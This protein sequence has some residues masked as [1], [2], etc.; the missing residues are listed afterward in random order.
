MGS[1]FLFMEYLKP[2]KHK[3]CINKKKLD[4]KSLMSKKT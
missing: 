2:V 1:V 4:Q 3:H